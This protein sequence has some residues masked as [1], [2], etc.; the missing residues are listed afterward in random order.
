MP[1]S[2]SAASPSKNLTG[3]PRVAKDIAAD[4]HNNIQKWNEKHVSGAQ[5]IKKISVLKCNS[6]QQFPN[7]LETLIGELFDVLQNLNIYANAL[8]FLSS[9][10]KALTKLHKQKEPLFISMNIDRMS[11]LVEEI[12]A[13]YK[14][15]LKV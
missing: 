1:E 5:I 15:E 2:P 4:V 12:S 8:T 3:L 9:Q 13:A 7:G 11:N 6:T 10:M 14:T